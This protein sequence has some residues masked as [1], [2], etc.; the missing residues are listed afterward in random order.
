[1]AGLGLKSSRNAALPSSSD[2]G[3]AED[4]EQADA[5]AEMEALEEQMIRGASQ[6]PLENERPAQLT[7]ELIRASVAA[8]KQSTKQQRPAG[9]EEEDRQI[10]ALLRKKVLRLDWLDIGR[11]ENLDAFTH[12][13]ELYLQHNLLETIEGLDDHSQLTFLA[14]AGN[15][16][17]ELKFLDLSMNYIEDFDVRDFPSSLRI[18]RLA[19]NP[20]TRHMPA[21]A[22]LFFER[23][24]HLVQIDQFRRP[25]VSGSG[26]SAALVAS[27]EIP[28]S[29]VTSSVGSNSTDADSQARV[30]PLPAIHS[31]MDQYRELQMEVELPQQ[32]QELQETQELH[33][34]E[35]KTAFNLADYEQQRSDR[36]AKW[37][38]QLTALTSR[39]RAQLEA[40][41]GS[42]ES[43]SSFRVRRSLALSRA[44]E[45]T[46]TA[47]ADA[48][49]HFKEVRVA[50]RRRRQ[51]MRN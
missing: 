40:T 36:M 19:G 33:E 11:I 8:S 9:P 27:S 35:G 29:S 42:S 14:L 41:S 1:L 34:A 48:A 23:L 6:M 43:G 50:V 32:E 21:Y 2:G 15:R 51:R 37:K 3:D 46:D 18:L 25:S 4:A 47:L 38:Q 44:R 49:S 12:V 26:A 16:I 20:F 28:S 10:A 7:M 5:N 17:R 39:T 13:Q 45:A 24:P 22:H 30:E 31:P